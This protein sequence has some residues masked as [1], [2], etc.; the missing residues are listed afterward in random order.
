MFDFFKN[1]KILTAVI[2]IGM[3]AIII[4]CGLLVG[5]SSSAPPSS[6][7]SEPESSQE[8]DPSLPESSP[9]SSDSSQ[10]QP[11]ASSGSSYIPPEEYEKYSLPAEMRGVMLRPGVDFLAGELTEE[12]IK[13][14]IDSVIA[15]TKSS[16]FN[17][18]IVESRFNNFVIY[19]SSIFSSVTD[20]FD[21]MQYIIDKADES[22]LFVFAIYDVFTVAQNSGAVISTSFN[23]STLN[24]IRSNIF[25]FASKYELDGILFDEYYLPVSSGGYISYVNNGAGIGYE[26]Y[27]YDASFSVLKTARSAVLEANTKINIGILADPVWANDTE[28]TYGS[29]TTAAFSSMYDA[30]CD[31]KKYIE[32]N[33]FD[34]ISVD[35]Y[36]SLTDSKIPFKNVASWWSALAIRN[37]LPLYPV[38]SADRVE[39]PIYEGWNNP[40]ELLMQL[41]E[42]E[43]LLGSCNGIFKTASV[44][45]NDISGSSASVINYYKTGESGFSGPSLEI[46][47]PESTT[48]QTSDSYFTFIGSSD[49]SYPLTI[50]GQKI[51]CDSL[52]NFSVKVSL[53]T[54][55]NTFILKHKDKTLV[56]KIT[57]FVTVIEQVSPNKNIQLSGETRF[58]VDV[59]A[60]KGSVV[61]ATLDGE[62]ITLTPAPA[63][64]YFDHTSNYQRYTGTFTAPV[65]SDS[66]VSL[67]NIVF[68]A[69][70]YG[71][72]EV[73]VG[74]SV[75][76]N[77]KAELPT[78]LSQAV[79]VEV[80]SDNAQTFSPYRL[81]NES[82]LSCFPIAKGT[83]DYI[84][85]DEIRYSF[86]NESYSYYL[87]SSGQLISKNDVRQTDNRVLDNKIS[88]MSVVSDERYTKIT[89]GSSEK[90]PYKLSYSSG[91]VTISFFHTSDVPNDMALDK[92]PLF[93]GASWN[94]STLSLPFLTQNGFLGVSAEYDA[95]GNLVFTFVN[96]PA[97]SLRDAVIVIDPGHGKGDS[98][99]A[100]LLP[101]F[102]EE[103]INQSLAKKLKAILE[104]KGAEVILIDTRY[105]AT[106]I[107]QRLNA[108]QSAKP[109]IFISLHAAASQDP[110]QKGVTVKYSSPFSLNFASKLSSAVASAIGTD[111]IGAKQGSFLITSSTEFPSVML[112]Y[113][114]ITNEDDYYSLISDDVQISIA[115]A[116]SDS[117]GS[118]LTSVCGNFASRRGVQL[119]DNAVIAIEDVKLTNTSV[120]LFSG[121][122]KL[123]NA[124]ISP[125]YASDKTLVW[126]SSDENIVTVDQAGKIT[127]V[128][129]GSA[130]ITVSTPDGSV[131]D[132]CTVTVRR[133]LFG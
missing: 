51:S 81:G 5:L 36:G 18:I 94:G 20:N 128:S 65:A 29:S 46:T 33:L 52:G 54:G 41:K 35:C 118:Y 105:S 121:Y 6:S 60:Y 101:N 34:F 74:G 61:T 55:E 63:D 87:L 45:F 39:S 50:N 59:W 92:N 1:K 58:S 90:A 2:I 108:A 56:Y 79:L 71:K 13:A 129:P 113:G 44:F 110:S 70:R 125:T 16:A 114:H 127:A 26:N 107:E 126:S 62:K 109:H 76:V 89:F 120:I 23:I 4:V 27:L 95:L 93:S 72:S 82:F 132:S 37:N 86:A 104:S 80:I 75:T 31:V 8:S 32:Q 9:E 48:H 17:S 106:S 112:E 53:D 98:G 84:V 83:L 119:S 25:E 133:S 131:S 11:P 96:P 64:D 3:V 117:I 122:S 21:V 91:A 15:Q 68:T 19:S 85:G 7:T 38:Y 49:P 42:V 78:D 47:A 88:S 30:F 115:T 111:N 43:Q 69:S 14:E 102:S 130:V 124:E 24:D 12:A 77:K 40:D 66:A 99:I 73:L 57:R 28:N 123:L 10:Y 103:T 67:G 97:Q 116:I 100:G 22:D